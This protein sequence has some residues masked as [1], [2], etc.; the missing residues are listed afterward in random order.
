MG[1]KTYKPTSPGRRSMSV[2]DYS[3]VTKKR[4]EKSLTEPLA[5]HSGRN[6]LGR[7]TVR[8]RGG[9]EKRLYRK[10]D[11][12]RNK[13][14][15]PAKVT[16]I[17]YDPN[18]SSFIALLIY[19][20]GE[21]RYIICPKDLKV[22]DEVISGTAVEPKT[23]NALPI[24]SIPLG[25]TIHNI[26]LSPKRGG[27]LAR[28]AG[29]YAQ[30]VAKEGN[31][32]IINLPSGESRKVLLTCRATIGQVGNLDHS[33]VR[34]GKAG[35]SRHMGKRPTVRGS[36]M[37]PVAHPM[38]GGEGRRAGGRHPV[39]PWGWGTKGRKTRKKNNPKDKF[40]VR[41]RK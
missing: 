41:R 22:G 4:P 1:V 26:E 40:I 17:E 25:L 37:N 8:H 11:F 6:A 15:I 21:E 3:E 5:K 34:I 23:G 13:D 9:S 38:G 28:S 31:Y 29:S 36:A 2:L 16:S 35:K 24:S 20:D 39:S 32:A 30:L 33:N 14:N 12:K 7:V 18:R 10:I 27:Q 19:A